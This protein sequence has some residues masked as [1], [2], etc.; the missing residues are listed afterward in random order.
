[1]ILGSI[2]VAVDRKIYTGKS[3]IV[4]K[5]I[6]VKMGERYV[7]QA[8]DELTK[9]H[10][11]NSKESHTALMP[12]KPGRSKMLSCF[13]FAVFAASSPKCI[14]II[15]FALIGKLQKVPRDIA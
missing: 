13:L 10:Q 14:R 2:F 6:I 11:G 1:M 12:K 9:N 7:G 15:L 5:T 3:E 4:A 8:I